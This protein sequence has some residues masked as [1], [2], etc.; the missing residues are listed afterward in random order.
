MGSFANSLFKIMLGWLQAVVSSVWY[1]FTSKD[2][3]LIFNWIGRNWILIAGILCIIG[4]AV[5][6]VVYI[7][8]WRPFRKWRPF[9]TKGGETDNEQKLT[10]DL[11]SDSA[12]P[13]GK[14]ARYRQYAATQQVIMS[15]NF[16]RQNPDLS[17][18]E[19]EKKD[20]ETVFSKP[21][22]EQT[23]ITNAGYIVPTDSPYRRP[24]EK[25]SVNETSVHPT[26]TVIADEK[27]EDKPVSLAPRRRRRIS[28]S[29]LFSDPEEELRSFDAPQHIID[30]RK[31]YREPV[32]PRGW[33]KSEDKGE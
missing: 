29:E 27:Q 20:P 4:L 23:M 30:S 32:Y 8:R 5:D 31:A 26:P 22:E 24:A 16:S 21:A 10:E 9:F 14:N 7:L 18:W 17:Q 13:E 1:A 3:S 33:N 2:G 15:R 12:I 19:A 28:V 11:S 25:Q 6:L